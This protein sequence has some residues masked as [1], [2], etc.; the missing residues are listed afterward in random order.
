MNKNLWGIVKETEKS[1]TYPNK[2]LKWKNK[3]DKSK[4]IIGLAMSNS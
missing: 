3:Y 4:S 1:S 2:F